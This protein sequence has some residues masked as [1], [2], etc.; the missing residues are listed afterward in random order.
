MREQ[1]RNERNQRSAFDPEYNEQPF[2][3]ENLH[4]LVNGEF[5]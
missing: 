5:D 1:Q 4:A 2:E 3:E